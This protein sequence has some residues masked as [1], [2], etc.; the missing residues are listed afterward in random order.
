M[1]NGPPRMNWT[2]FQGRSLLGGTLPAVR[3]LTSED[4]EVSFQPIVDTGEGALIGHEAFARCLRPEYP[5][6]PDLF[7]KAA[8][9]QACGYV[10][11]KIRE[12]TFAARINAPLFVNVHPD[13]LSARWLVRPDDPMCFHEYPVFLE[14]TEA[15]AFTHF[16]LCMSVLG[17]VC[18]RIG[19]GLVVDDFGAEHSGIQRVFD[20]NP[21]LIKLDPKLVRAAVVDQRR[22]A[23]L[24]HVVSLCHDLGA[25]V[26]VKGVE[27]MDQLKAAVDVNADAVQG[28][29][30][31]EPALSPD[32]VR[33]LLATGRHPTRSPRDATV[34]ASNSWTHSDASR[35][36]AASA[37]TEPAPGAAVV[38]IAVPKQQPVRE[39]YFAPLIRRP[40]ASD[41]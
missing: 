7:K 36:A 24:S 12:V 3:E 22:Y 37:S 27:S 9:E 1:R 35:S 20:L 5:Y 30:L 25:R 28:H 34:K 19:A 23:A 15:A 16:A 32:P 38:E 33:W 8:T 26:V 39:R 6:T 29:F 18:E 13:E 2:A 17:E 14:V 31:A 11:R 4:F 10:G 40:D 21:K 41:E